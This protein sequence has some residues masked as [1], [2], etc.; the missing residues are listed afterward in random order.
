MLAALIFWTVLTTGLGYAIGKSKGRGFQGALLGFWLNLIG[1]LIIAVLPPT[2]ETQ[3][4]RDENLASAIAKA[5]GL[6]PSS[7]EAVS[8][9]STNRRQQALQS[10]VNSH[11]ELVEDK[12]P[13]ALSR[14]KQL[15]DEE[16]ARLLFLDEVQAVQQQQ[17]ANTEEIGHPGEGA[18]E[19]PSPGIPAQEADL[20]RPKSSGSGAQTWPPS[21]TLASLGALAILPFF[22]Y[23]KDFST[24]FKGMNPLGG[25]VNFLSLFLPFVALGLLCCAIGMF[26]KALIHRNLLIAA[27]ATIIVSDIA[28][29]VYLSDFCHLISDPS[30]CVSIT[31]WDSIKGVVGFYV[32]GFAKF[33]LISLDVALIATGASVVVALIASSHVKEIGGTDL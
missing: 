12:S 23:L 5:H 26:R 6:T 13:E 31:F 17:V 3:R 2:A 22:Y 15:V 16:E 25:V 20:S 9:T 33:A 14:L 1:I 7:A 18:A 8:V 24:M 29:L 11:P 21:A 32:T 10:V 4:A 19:Y 28:Y 30:S 27:F